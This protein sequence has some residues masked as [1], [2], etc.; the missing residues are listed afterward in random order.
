MPARSTVT[1]LPA[2]VKKWLDAALIKN[3]FGQ[4]ELLSA[5]LKKRGYDISK[6]SLHRY[7]SAFEERLGAMRAATEQAKAIVAECGDE[8]GATNEALL[9]LVSENLFVALTSSDPEKRLGTEWMPE[10]AK[11]IGNITRAS[12]VNKTY[13]AKVRKEDAGK[14][15]K[16]EAEAAAATGKG[17]KALDPETLRRVREEIYGF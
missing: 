17:K 13:A 4:Y 12:V 2:T 9:R 5:Q 6:S 10:V 7:G 8:E 1:K 15:A 11:A 16:L 14:L 3:A